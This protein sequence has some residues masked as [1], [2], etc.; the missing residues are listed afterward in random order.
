MFVFVECFSNKYCL[1]YFKCVEDVCK[2]KDE[3]IKEGKNCKLGEML[4][5]FFLILIF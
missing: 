4:L 3:F 1:L 5:K 2:C